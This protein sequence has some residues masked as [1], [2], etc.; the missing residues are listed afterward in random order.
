[1][2]IC[3]SVIAISSVIFLYITDKTDNCYATYE[4]DYPISYEEYL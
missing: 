3:Q 1:M 2:I 4:Y